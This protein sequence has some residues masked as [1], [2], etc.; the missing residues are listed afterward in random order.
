MVAL[1]TTQYPGLISHCTLL[2]IYLASFFVLWFVKN[3][4]LPTS[5]Y[6]TECQLK[7]KNRGGLGTR[8]TCTF[9]STHPI[10]ITI[11]KSDRYVMM[12][13]ILLI[14]HDRCVCMVRNITHKQN[15]LYKIMY[16]GQEMH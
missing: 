3:A 15:T 2:N 7:N 12:T 13:C 4:T 6:Y 16:S 5:V 9:L 10:A 1:I 8:Q 11:V 14:G